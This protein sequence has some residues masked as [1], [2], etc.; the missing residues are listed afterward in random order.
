MARQHGYKGEVSIDPAGTTTYAPV[1][2]VR[3]WTGDFTRDAVDATCFGDASKVTLM[4]LR[5][6]K[7][8]LEFVWD[9]ATTPDE[10]IAVAFGDTPAG[11]KLTPSTLTPT[12]F[13]SGLAYRHASINV[14]H[15]GVNTGAANWTGAGDFDISTG[16]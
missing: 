14:A 5:N 11:L 7:G 10:L 15:D 13:F 16:P 3:S 1:A 8:S 12:K 6:A 4:G 2:S 9:P